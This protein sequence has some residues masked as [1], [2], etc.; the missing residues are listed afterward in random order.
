ML[1]GVLGGAVFQYWDRIFPP[2]GTKG[3]GGQSL[4]VEVVQAN[5]RRAFSLNFTTRFATRSEF[6]AVAR[7]ISESRSEVQKRVVKFT[8]IGDSVAATTLRNML[9]KLNTLESRFKAMEPFVGDNVRLDGTASPS[10]TKLFQ[11]AEAVRLEYLAELRAFAQQ[12]HVPLPSVP[13]GSP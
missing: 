8:A 2:S 6:E 5:Y 12:T 13:V 9:E 4:A 7:S 3:D 1:V 10:L 11:E